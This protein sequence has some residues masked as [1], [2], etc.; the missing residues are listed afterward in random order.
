MQ[1]VGY[2]GEYQPQL[3]DLDKCTRCGLCEQACPTY[4]LLH[5]EPDSPRGRVY[6]MKQV[7]QGEGAIDEHFSRHLYQC[8]GCRA[9]ET[10]CPAGVPYGKLLERARF[11]IEAREDVPSAHRGWRRFRS[12]AFQRILPNPRLFDAALFPAWLLQR[13]PGAL[14]LA[15]V[16]PLPKKISQLV[17]MIPR[18]QAE[19]L[20]VTRTAPPASRLTAKRARVGLFLGCI[21]RSLFSRVHR[22]TVEVLSQNGCEVIVP[23]EQ[24][25]CGA[26]NV[27]AG[28]RRFATQ[29]AQRNIRAFAGHNLDAIIVDSA[30]CGAHLKEYPELLG[31]SPQVAAFSSKVRDVTEFLATMQLRPFNHPT[32]ARVAYQDACHLAHAQ[33]IR[34]Q[35]R[36]LLRQLPALDYVE[37][38]HADQCCGAAGVY[39]L[40]HP[41]LS[42]AILAK[43]LDDIE[44]SQAAIVATTNPGCAM[45][46]QAGIIQ[47]GMP[48]RVCHVVEL[49]AEAYAGP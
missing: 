26:L 27:H 39:S 35:P 11:Q 38:P 6:L 37:L 1:P 19:P 16:M 29:M 43:K 48:V 34:R 2:V 28:E 47:R 49:L 20:N 4:R 5:F 17:R 9:C 13:V 45:Q 21:M 7:A 23:R 14:N 12:F 40:T 44:C 10:V 33:G 24:W 36:E 32:S 30:G 18:S 41:A 42:Q 25:C 31:S 46:L 3:G 22:A 15:Q 8:L